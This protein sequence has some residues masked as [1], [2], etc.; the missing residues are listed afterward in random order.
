MLTVPQNGR[1]FSL[2]AHIVGTST[3]KLTCYVSRCSR[4][5]FWSGLRAGA[6]ARFLIAG[7]G[8]RY[9]P[10]SH[11]VEHAGVDRL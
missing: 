11:P 10:G 2:Y 7:F 4:F 8:F 3:S 1:L 9:F 5:S 6:G